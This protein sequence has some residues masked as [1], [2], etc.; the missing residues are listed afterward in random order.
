[1]RRWRAWWIG[2]RQIEE[3]LRQMMAQQQVL[4]RWRNAGLKIRFMSDGRGLP[5]QSVF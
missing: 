3:R 5:R 2:R 1:M 4:G